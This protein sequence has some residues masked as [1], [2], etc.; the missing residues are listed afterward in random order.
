[1][2]AIEYLV[3][4]NAYP[5][6]IGFMDFQKAISVAPNDVLCH[7]IPDDRPIQGAADQTGTT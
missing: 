3:G 5:S 7:G 4:E 2:K 6:G 1:M